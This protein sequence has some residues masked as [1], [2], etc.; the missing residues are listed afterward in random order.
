MDRMIGRMMIGVLTAMWLGPALAATVVT[1]DAV[2]TADERAVLAVEDDW[3]HAEVARDG[4]TL[5]RVLADEFVFNQNDGQLSGRGDL[6]EG[7]VAGNMTGQTIIERS[8]MVDGDTAVIFG[9]TELRFGGDGEA[10]TISLLRYTTVY[11]KRGGQWRAIA[12]HMA[13]RTPL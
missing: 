11:V 10:E 12:L 4:A 6:I 7:I 5:E 2:L 3:I 13:Q 8:V 9:T 1:P